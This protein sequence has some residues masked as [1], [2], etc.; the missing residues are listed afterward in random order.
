MSAKPYSDDEIAVIRANPFDKERIWLATVDTLKARLASAEAEVARLK[1]PL[2]PKRPYEPKVGD[3]VGYFEDCVDDRN[4]RIVKALDGEYARIAY[5]YGGEASLMVKHMTF[6]RPATPAERAAAGLPPEP[7]ITAPS[8][9]VAKMDAKPEVLPE[10]LAFLD[11][12]A[13][14]RTE[15]SHIERPYAVYRTTTAA[16]A[17]LAAVA[18]R[19]G[20]GK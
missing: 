9:T 4:S 19:D 3:V 2:E 12:M 20:G 5:A 8:S 6:L 1:A 11:A 15:E 10:H 17:L 14:E 7:A 16:R 13:A 18:R